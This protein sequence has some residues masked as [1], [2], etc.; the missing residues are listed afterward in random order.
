MSAAIEHVEGR[1]GDR[2]WKQYRTGGVLGPIPEALL[3]PMNGYIIAGGPTRKS[4][5][6]EL[7]KWFPRPEEARVFAQQS[8]GKVF[9]LH[10]L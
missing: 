3:M 7:R 1:L 4:I 2:L 10:P 8:D 5:L 6:A 9:H